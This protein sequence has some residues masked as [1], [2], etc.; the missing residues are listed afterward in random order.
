MSLRDTSTGREGPAGTFPDEQAES[1]SISSCSAGQDDDHDHQDDRANR[2]QDDGYCDRQDQ[3]GEQQQITQA[4]R[5]LLSSRWRESPSMNSS[6]PQHR[7]QSS[8][9]QP[10]P[11]QRHGRFDRGIRGSSP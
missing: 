4:A 8:Q 7:G 6:S 1:G 10:G 2:D 11:Q 3:A 9:L 5:P